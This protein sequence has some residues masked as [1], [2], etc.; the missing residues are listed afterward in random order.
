MDRDIAR[1]LIW[2]LVIGGILFLV[3]RWYFVEYLLF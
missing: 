1:F 3:A 2:V